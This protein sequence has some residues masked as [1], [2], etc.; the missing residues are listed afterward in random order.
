MGALSFNE[1]FPM[2]IESL[3]TDIHRVYHLDS[4]D[5]LNT[6]YKTNFYSCLSSKETALWKLDS[7]TLFSLYQDEIEYCK[8]VS[9][10][11]NGISISIK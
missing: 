9:I 4:T 3:C 7:N 10:S 6:L 11:P 8:L 1:I 2:H 5:A